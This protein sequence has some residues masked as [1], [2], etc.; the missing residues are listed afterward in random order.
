MESLYPFVV[1]MSGGPSERKERWKKRRKG[2]VRSLEESN[3]FPSLFSTDELTSGQKKMMRALTRKIYGMG[4]NRLLLP[5][6]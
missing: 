1:T 3:S 5:D 2:R 6:K 4:L